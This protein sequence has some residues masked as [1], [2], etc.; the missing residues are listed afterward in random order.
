M[1]AQN[2]CFG[3]H[4]SAVAESCKNRHGKCFT[5]QDCVKKIGSC[6]KRNMGPREKLCKLK[7]SKL[8]RYSK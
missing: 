8:A 7:K 4:K 6:V 2:S 1:G 3:K 5:I